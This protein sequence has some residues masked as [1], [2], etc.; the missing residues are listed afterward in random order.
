M[1]TAPDLLALLLT[2]KVLWILAALYHLLVTA[3]GD[4]LLDLD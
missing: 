2:D 4:D 3:A 1:S